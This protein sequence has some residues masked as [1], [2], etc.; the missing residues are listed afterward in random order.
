MNPME[1]VFLRWILFIFM[2]FFRFYKLTFLLDVAKVDGDVCAA[3][4]KRIFFW[5]HHVTLLQPCPE[6]FNISFFIWFTFI[7]L[8]QFKN[9]AKVCAIFSH[10]HVKASWI[11]LLLVVLVLSFHHKKIYKH[12]CFSKCKTKDAFFFYPLDAVKLLNFSVCVVFSS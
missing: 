4:G 9:I 8:S 7:F 3:T 6:W 2:G 5:L 10:L 1:I 11:L 12:I